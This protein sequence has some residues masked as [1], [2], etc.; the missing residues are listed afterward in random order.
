MNHCKHVGENHFKAVNALL[1]YYKEVRAACP[2]V[3]LYWVQVP[4]SL[5][6]RI[7]SRGNVGQT[8]R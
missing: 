6:P 3:R 4:P 7:N 1:E 2:D 8:I 5:D